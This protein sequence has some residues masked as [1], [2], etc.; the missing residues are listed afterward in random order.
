M[1]TLRGERLA[2]HTTLRVGGPAQTLVIAES[3]QELIDTVRDADARG[4]PLFVFGKGSNIVIDDA[5]WHGVAVKIATT[6]TQHETAACAG[7]TVTV[8]AGETWDD[9]VA[10]AIANDWSG[11]EAMSGIPGS[12]GAT[13][14]QNVGAYGQDV[15][16][17]IARVRAFDRESGQ[18]RTFHAADCGFGYRTSMFKQ[19]APRF[20]ILDVQFQLRLGEQ[21]MPITYPELAARLGVQVGERSTASAVREAVLALRR[22][23]AMVLDDGDHDTW[24]VGSF[25]M[26][27]TVASEGVPEGAPHWEAGPDLVKVSAAWLV[28]NSGTPKGF[29]IGNAAT[30]SKH[31]LSITNRGGASAVEV[32]RLAQLIQDR[33]RTTFGIDLQMEPQYVANE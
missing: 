12:V 25:F 27:P 1:I 3:E 21:S 2:P 17:T 16:Q 26:N 7:A 10:S 32:M 8:A 6:G 15:S 24:S 18:V 13:P 29:A 23:K 5:G 19:H 20:V 4:I 11:V 22:S 9:F 30:S 14:I 31:A 33:V 28:E